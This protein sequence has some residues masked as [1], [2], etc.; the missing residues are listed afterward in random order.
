MHFVRIGSKII[1]LDHV[2]HVEIHDD[3]LTLYYAQVIDTQGKPLQLRLFN[4][5]AISLLARLEKYLD[6][7]AGTP[8]R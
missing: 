1:N 5:E 6:M 3:G 8:R 4:P 7:P 2:A